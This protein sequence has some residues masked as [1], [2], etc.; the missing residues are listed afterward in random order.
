[1]ILATDK[2][3]RNRF[4]DCSSRNSYYETR[5]H[6]ISAFDS[7]LNDF[8]YRLADEV[9]NGYAGNEGRAYCDVLD[10][11]EVVVGCAVLVWYRMPSG[12]YEFTGYLA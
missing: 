9:G 8:G 6:A 12:R 4:C 10:G 3:V 5:G 11:N 1:M 7:A 2:A